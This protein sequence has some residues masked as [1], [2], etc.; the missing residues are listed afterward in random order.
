M[1]HRMDTKANYFSEICTW[2]WSPKEYISDKYNSVVSV[3]HKAWIIQYFYHNCIKDSGLVL[4]CNLQEK[5][6]LMNSLCLHLCKCNLLTFFIRGLHY[7]KLFLIKIVCFFYNRR[8]KYVLQ[9]RW[10]I[11]KK[12]NLFC[13]QIQKKHDN[14]AAG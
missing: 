14:P 4:Y 13:V 11:R 8:H 7:D 12:W 6:A 5:R 1:Y 9:L 3:P 2:G 10:K